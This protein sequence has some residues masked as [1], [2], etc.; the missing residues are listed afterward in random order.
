MPRRMKGV[1]NGKRKTGDPN[2]GEPHHVSK[3]KEISIRAKRHKLPGD[4]NP[5]RKLPL[6][7]VHAH[8]SVLSY[9]QQ[10]AKQQAA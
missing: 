4:S 3:P 6:G 1:R 7:R 5:A 2:A 10:R 8:G 9:G